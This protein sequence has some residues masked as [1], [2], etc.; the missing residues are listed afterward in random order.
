M[1]YYLNNWGFRTGFVFHVCLIKQSTFSLKGRL[2]KGKEGGESGG[3]GGG[4]GGVIEEEE[5]NYYLAV[6]PRGIQVIA[7]KKKISS[8]KKCDL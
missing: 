2:R 7:Q 5:D 3:G 6:M 4:G 1:Q 8:P